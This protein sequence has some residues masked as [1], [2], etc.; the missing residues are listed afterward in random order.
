[1]SGTEL[2]DLI[3]IGRI[4]RP[5]G[6]TG[7]LRIVSYAQAMETFLKAGYIF[8]HQPETELDKRKVVS[9][10]SY[11]S[12][13]L[14]RLSGVDSIEQA[15]AFRGAEILIR[16]DSLKKNQDEFFWY[17]LLGLHVYLTTGEYLGVLK[18]IFSTG[19]NDVYVVKNREKEVLI[20]AIHQ[21]VKNIDIP[22]KKMS[23]LPLKGLLDIS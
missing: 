18:E 3:L 16:K 19:S 6:V 9:I 10:A 15:A 20:P 14:L 23:I 11:G 8:L 21:V 13:Y 12:A 5:H 17:E 4:I 1:L 7:L 2:S 22:R